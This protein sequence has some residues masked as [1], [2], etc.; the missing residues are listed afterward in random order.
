MARIRKFLLLPGRERLLLVQATFLLVVI[1]VG[2]SLVP[3]RMLRRLLVRLARADKT[4]KAPRQS[5]ID[6]VIW[7]LKAAGR[8]FPLAG[9]CLTEALA[10]Y[11]LLGRKGYSTDLRIGVTRD[12][13]G[14]FLAHAWLEKGDLIVIGQIG[15]EHER[16]IPFPAIRGLGPF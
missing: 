12:A 4:S 16:Y 11:A 13:E 3:F 5:D 6:R 9:T 8:T 2:L 1:R 10:G 14:R 7:A 15:A